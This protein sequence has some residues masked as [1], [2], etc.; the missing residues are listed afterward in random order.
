MRL[1]LTGCTF[2][3]AAAEAAVE[4]GEVHPVGPK[5]ERTRHVTFALEKDMILYKKNEKKH[6]KIWSVRWLSLSSQDRK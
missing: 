6:R 5:R 1:K 3:E 2:A 4:A